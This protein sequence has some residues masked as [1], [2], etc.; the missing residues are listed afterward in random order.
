GQG[1]L[2]E[3]LP[4]YWQLLFQKYGFD[5]YDVIRPIFWKNEKVK[6]YYRQNMFIA[7]KNKLPDI[8]AAAPS[9][10]TYIHPGHYDQLHNRINYLQTNPGIRNSFKLL[11]SAIRNKI[12]RR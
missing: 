2:N 7:S 6:W 3:Q 5:F 11:L 8:A 1:H 4:G 10:N 12:T 9:I